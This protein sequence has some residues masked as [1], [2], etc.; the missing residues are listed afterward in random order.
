MNRPRQTEGFCNPACIHHLTCMLTRPLRRRAP[1][2]SRILSNLV[3]AVAVFSA[4]A[5]MSIAQ[6]TESVTTDDNPAAPEDT[7]P[8][9][10]EFLPPEG[11]LVTW[12]DSLEEGRAL[13]QTRRA[14]IVVVAGAT[15]CGPCQQLD[16]EIRRTAVQKELQ[17]WVAVH[18]NIDDQPEAAKTLAVSSI[19]AIRLLS[20]DGRLVASREGLLP[21]DE[22]T[23]WLRVQHET[24]AQQASAEKIVG[25]LTAGNVV[26]ILN[27]FRSREATI[28]ES[29][30]SR[31]VA[32]PEVAAA[33]VVARFA[34]VGL[35]EQLAFLELLDSWQAPVDGL[36]PWIP[37]SVTAERITR[38][39]QWVRD[40]RFEPQDLSGEL[41]P[42]EVLEAGRIIRSLR[43]AAPAE[44][45]ALRE[46]LARMGRKTLPLIRAMLEHESSPSGR[47][48]LMT[49]RYRVAGTAELVAEWPDGIERLAD[50][51]FET[52]IA[53][54]D[55]LVEIATKREEALLLELFGDPIPFVRELAM[56]GLV[57]V[58]GT[59]A[60]GALMQL[61]D[62][63][64]ANVRA[65][66]LK[67]LAAEPVES[68]V[69]R[70]SQYAQLETDPDLIVHAIRFLREIQKPEAVK[71][72]SQFLTHASWRVR[73]EGADGISRLIRKSGMSE[74][75]RDAEL[76]R[77][78]VQLLND[79]DDYVAGIAVRTI[80]YVNA[81]DTAKHL[82]SVA[83]TRPSIAA[84]AVAVLGESF[85]G[86]QSIT[87]KMIQ[88][89]GHQ[90]ADIRAAATV[91]LVRYSPGNHAET[92][93]AALQDKQQTVQAAV[94]DAIFTEVKSEIRT[95]LNKIRAQQPPTNPVEASTHN[96]ESLETTGDQIANW[97]GKKMDDL[98]VSIR[99]ERNLTG[100]V[101]QIQDS[102]EPLVNSS[103]SDQKLLAALTLHIIGNNDAFEILEQAA[104][105]SQQLPRLMTVFPCL[106]W[107]EKSSLV[108]ITL[109][110]SASRD[111][112]V[113][114]ADGLSGTRDNRSPQLLQT[115]LEHAL[116]DARLVAEIMSP[117]KQSYFATYHSS[118][119]AAESFERLRLQSQAVQMVKGGS[120]W[121]KTA[122]MLLLAEAD[123]AQLQESAQTLYDDR[124]Q[125]DDI[126]S[127]ALRVLLS[128]DKSA[129]AISR[130]INALQTEP[131][132]VAEPAL[133][134]LTFG[135]SGVRHLSR[136]LP[137]KVAETRI[138]IQT[139]PGPIELTAPADLTPSTLAPFA[140]SGDPTTQVAVNY[141]L[142]MMKEKPDITLVIQY[143]L[144][145]P[146]D[147]L[148]R[149][150][151]YRAMAA[152]DD[153]QFAKH[154]SRMYRDLKSR[155][156]GA[157]GADFYWTLRSMK[158]S[159]AAK[160]ADRILS[161][162]KDAENAIPVP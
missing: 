23:R 58:S 80:R 4:L 140:S 121:Q 25:R 127:D 122:G 100:W 130:A 36:D 12:L 157:R 159:S 78:F 67:Q 10:V 107:E 115:I 150:L 62:D 83:E 75:R 26:T 109:A 50:A 98:L 144:K 118:T 155:T 90:Q 81:Q 125:P 24:A 57:K 32:T 19:P 2:A 97:R 110:A 142:A 35:A 124:S 53:A 162:N 108:S 160:L 154:L 87:S 133:H 13:A 91:S 135:R 64:D 89:A 28:R 103:E 21:A 61:L 17:R 60:T 33:P 29:A 39:E 105:D 40:R 156:W 41:S 66:V 7:L 5:E 72:M 15:W 9:V 126:R 55:E 96:D 73:A 68:L 88:F 1:A 38:L 11:H 102:L 116:A 79:E 6:N 143:W 56:Q 99:T 134:Y 145:A 31:L 131:P 138:P 34:D 77:A 95:R 147:H 69:T 14:P 37:D 70:I 112:L 65:A 63:P 18:L 128:Y 76:G 49:A 74:S 153:D 82:I 92:I 149:R 137:L 129:T 93:V 148:R 136:L 104:A 111:D 47:Q 151:A 8:Q 48:R 16:I 161:E 85:L 94:S 120:R 71:A 52:R 54:A 43:T 20:P 42:L 30:I 106:T 114:I 44:S 158:C 86:Q 45:V 146:N 141:L 101:Y 27:D 132:G 123:P 117:L 59:D 152:I 51:D 139:T 84:S 22:L 113:L 46:Q 119:S 3:V